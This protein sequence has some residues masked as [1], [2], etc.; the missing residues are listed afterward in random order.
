MKF[1]GSLTVFNYKDSNLPPINDSVSGIFNNFLFALS[2][3]LLTNFLIFVYQL[4]RY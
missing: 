4:V 3:L 1:S 2:L